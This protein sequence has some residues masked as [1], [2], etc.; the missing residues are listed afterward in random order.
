MLSRG[1]R[2]PMS[3]VAP[4][5]SSQVPVLSFSSNDDY[6][7]VFAWSQRESYRYLKVPLAPP[8]YSNRYLF[9]S[10]NKVPLRVAIGE[11]ISTTASSSVEELHSAFYAELA[12]LFELHKREWG[13]E[14]R[15][16]RFV[17]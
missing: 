4:P 8:Y 1:P 14:H 17:D 7:N 9:P 2:S 5:W 11:R 10:T 6:D 15:V 12:R 3:P 13:Y 16:L